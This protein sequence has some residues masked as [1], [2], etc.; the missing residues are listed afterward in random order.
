LA[1]G[2]ALLGAR[3]LAR[4]H[5]RWERGA[6]GEERVG[7]ILDGLSGEGWLA[8]HDLPFERGNIDH[9]LVGPGGL[10]TIETKSHRGRIHAARIDE[11][12]L[13][14][15]LAEGRRVEQATGRRVEPLLVFSRAYLLP[16]VSRRGGVTVLPARM[17]PKYLTRYGRVLSPWEVGA[18]GERVSRALG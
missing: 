6:R 13:R 9:V 7:A 16:A 5:G 17:L 8:L 3:R 4:T 2:A 14:Q 18:L 12:M 15:A 10:F 11:S 1:I